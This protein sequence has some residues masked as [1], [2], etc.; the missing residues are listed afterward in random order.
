MPEIR[1]NTR[2]HVFFILNVLLLALAL[3]PAAG[4]AT[5]TPVSLALDGSYG[6]DLSYWPAIS[7]DGRYVVFQSY[8]SNL[9]PNDTN[10][11][12]DIFVRDLVTGETTRVSVASDGSQSNEPTNAS[13]PW[14]SIS[15]DGRYVAFSSEA[16]NLVDNDTN[17]QPDIFVH[18]R[19]TGK[20]IRVSV[21]SD[22]TQADENSMF[23]K[24]SADG[25]YVAF[26]SYACSLVATPLPSCPKG[27]I[28][29]MI[30]Q[31]YVRDLQT[32]T[33]VLVSTG[34]DG[35]PGNSSSVYPSI[36]ADGRYV[37]FS[38][39]ATNLVANDTNEQAGLINSGRDVFVHDLQT[40]ETTRV[41]VSSSGIQGNSWSD[42]PSISGDGNVIA[43]VSAATNFTQVPSGVSE[44]FVHNRATG[45]TVLASK[46]S[47]GDPAN[48]TCW[49]VSISGSG[50]Y[51]AF[52]TLATN[53]GSAFGF[54]VFLH[55]L[56]TGRTT[57]VSQTSDGQPATGWSFLPRS[58]AA[59]S[60]EGNRIVFRSDST[61]F[62]G[63]DTN[64][65]ADVFVRDTGDPVIQAV[66]AEVFFGSVNVS[67]V[68][69]PRTLTLA[70]TGSSDLVISRLS[71]TG[72]NTTSFAMQNDACSGQK[73]VPGANCTVQLFFEPE[74]PGSKSGAVEVS[75]NAAS[76]SMLLVP[77]T[78]TGVREGIPDISVSPRWLLF[79]RVEAGSNSSLQ[80]ITVSNKGTALLTVDSVA[81]Q[82]DDT[83]Q[84]GI[85]NDSCTGQTIPAGS[86][87]TVQ[88]VFLPTSVNS[89]TA[90]L[91]VA[92]ND[93]DSPNISVFLRGNANNA[94]GNASL[95]VT[96]AVIH[97]TI[98]ELVISDSSAELPGQ[99]SP[100]VIVSFR[101]SSV[102]SDVNVS[103]RYATLPANPVFYKV[104]QS[105]LRTLYPNNQ[106]SGVSNVVLNGKNFSFKIRDNSECDSD[107]AVG[108]IYDP[109]VVAGDPSESGGGA[110]APGNQGKEGCFIATAAYGS[111]LEPEVMALR[112]FRD[113]Y[114]LT[115]RAG[116]LFVRLY[117]AYS[118]PVAAAIAK[119]EVLRFSVRGALTPVV[120]AL[121]YPGLFAAFLFPSFL[122]F[123]ALIRK[124]RPLMHRRQ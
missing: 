115:N 72:D 67:A 101:A 87:C 41:S 66:P 22:G 25:R 68:S 94:G 78:G 32:G 110:A 85:Q 40:G 35:T 96:A 97:S 102:D 56:E 42:Y 37:A 16:T 7:A 26:Q 49:N 5:T 62:G 51:V 109:V 1:R 59:I 34:L 100:Q 2:L 88:I 79:N 80:T 27:D 33:T 3:S 84:F 31:V 108:V 47:S 38:S 73:L 64:G 57:V 50:R 4:A 53:L 52:D 63:N 21:A 83:E 120:Y 106:C 28:K 58:P 61:N 30:S 90:E 104:M 98:N 112:K 76:N 121:K 8:A 89:K 82:G 24:L 107:P 114:L 122:L 19:Q 20:T 77:L 45:T 111:Y 91:A 95:D 14:S 29:I 69:Q 60:A 93:P 81:L 124:Y 39:L 86:Q 18:D 74:S 43:F 11:A 70:N 44:I 117:Y 103:L 75:S 65:T 118:P 13:W 12:P 54:N 46:N 119:S 15:G 99:I 116:R 55:D 6:N 71:L 105:G 48:D 9:V 123:I 23:P 17:G 36:S 113:R 10:G 92:S